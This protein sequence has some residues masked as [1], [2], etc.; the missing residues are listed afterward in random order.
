MKHDTMVRILLENFSSHPYGNGL[1]DVALQVWFKFIRQSTN[2]N[3][4]REVFDLCWQ[5][6][7]KGSNKRNVARLS[8]MLFSKILSYVGLI[9][10][11]VYWYTQISG[12]GGKESEREKLYGWADHENGPRL[13]TIMLV[14]KTLFGF[15]EDPERIRKYLFRDDYAAFDQ[16]VK[17]RRTQDFRNLK[18]RFIPWTKY[19]KKGINLEHSRQ[20]WERGNVV[21]IIDKQTVTAARLKQQQYEEERANLKR[22]NKRQA[23]IDAQKKSQ[24]PSGVNPKASHQM[25]IKFMRPKTPEAHLDTSEI[26]TLSGMNPVAMWHKSRG[27]FNKTQ[28]AAVYLAYT[29]NVDMVIAQESGFGGIKYLI[30][31]A[32]DVSSWDDYLSGFGSP[33]AAFK[34]PYWIAKPNGDLYKARMDKK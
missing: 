27:N 5:Y 16:F 34:K 18:A 22:A 20:T 21:G 17:T 8:K 25:D 26:K 32:K 2:E 33:E 30:I 12:Y 11:S 14:E 15:F 3:T 7:Q 19:P 23:D 29:K 9:W 1:D 13:L 24:M 10:Y 28:L 31:P 6:L 4:L